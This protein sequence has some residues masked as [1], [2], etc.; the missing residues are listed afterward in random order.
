MV[1]V[2][3]PYA[4]SARGLKESAAEAVAL[5]ARAAA[6]GGVVEE[7][8]GADAVDPT[9]GMSAKQRKL[10]ELRLKLN[11]GRKKNQAAVVEEKKRVDAPDEY[12]NAQKRK[13]REA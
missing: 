10:F 11:E 7:H 1:G 8:L 6:T 13:N 12:A 5:A 3:I 2:E 9:A 4:A